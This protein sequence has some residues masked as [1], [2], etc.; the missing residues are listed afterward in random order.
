M[1]AAGVACVVALA[2]TVEGALGFGATLVA[3]SVGAFLVPVPALLPALLPLNLV[4]SASIVARDMRH[5]D[6]AL[7]F[8]RIL[9]LMALGA[10]LG[11]FGL[12]W[13]PAALATRA[14]GV[15]VL[16]LAALGLFR[17]APLP[18]LASPA[19]F[20]AAGAVHGAF[21]TGG[22]LVVAG[23]AARDQDAHKSALRATL[24]ALWLLLNLAL[25]A[26]FILDAR[27][28]DRAAGL[29]VPAGI[30]ALVGGIFGAKLHDALDA[31]LFTRV[32]WAALLVAGV[33]LVLR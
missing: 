2:F 21:G 31:A 22:P 11:Y 13:L 23:L 6:R 4:L 9:P 8:R 20:F 17:R 28:D 12:A 30:G 18:A 1:I 5:V 27:F 25:L 10:P 14:F 19:L 32:V 24:S 15:V 33:L 16:L 3:L 26:A 7:L 29:I